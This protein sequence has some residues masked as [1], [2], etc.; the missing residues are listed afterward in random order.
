MLSRFSRQWSRSIGHFAS[1]YVAE[2]QAHAGAEV[3]IPPGTG[4]N[5]LN[6]WRVSVAAG[7]GRAALHHRP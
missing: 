2:T 7:R 1:G 5:G 6:I 4:S 3:E